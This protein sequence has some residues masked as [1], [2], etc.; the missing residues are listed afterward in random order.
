[1][2]RKQVIT[3]QWQPE[4]VELLKVEAENQEKAAQVLAEEY[5]LD[6]LKKK[7]KKK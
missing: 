2:S 4:T 5:V 3:M 1:M 7:K 6:G